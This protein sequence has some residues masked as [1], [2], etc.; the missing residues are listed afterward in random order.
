MQLEFSTTLFERRPLTR[1]TDNQ[2]GGRSN[3]LLPFTFHRC[4]VAVANGGLMIL[5]RG[6]PKGMRYLGKGQASVP[7]IVLG[8]DPQTILAKTGEATT[9]VVVVQR[10]HRAWAVPPERA[11]RSR[12]DIIKIVG[13]RIGECFLKHALVNCGLVTR[14]KGPN[15]KHRR[16]IGQGMQLTPDP[17]LFV[18]ARGLLSCANPATTPIRRERH[19]HIP[20]LSREN[21]TPAIIRS[22]FWSC[23]PLLNSRR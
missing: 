5:L 22:V 19:H 12:R 20:T 4:P 2:V 18:Q 13:T 15:G 16:Q 23:S 1:A 7:E 3:D 9:L 14:R 8:S 21:D 10:E 17:T 6:T 11:M